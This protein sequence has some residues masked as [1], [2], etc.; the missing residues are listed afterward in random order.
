M[1][2]VDP[3]SSAQKMGLKRAD[4][5]LEVN[6]QDFRKFTLAKAEE[7][8]RESTHLSIT[9]KT[10]WIGVKVILMIYVI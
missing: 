7:L 9:L 1:L 2:S 3:D 8:M 4:E 5:I 6:G 10:N